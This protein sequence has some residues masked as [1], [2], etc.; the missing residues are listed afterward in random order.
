MAVQQAA[1]CLQGELEPIVLTLENI[2]THTFDDDK[3]P[4]TQYYGISTYIPR[5]HRNHILVSDDSDGG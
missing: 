5:K 2:S 1:R 4:S 3:P